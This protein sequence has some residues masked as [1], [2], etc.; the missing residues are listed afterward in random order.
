MRIFALQHRKKTFYFAVLRR[1][2]K[3]LEP[4]N[5]AALRDESLVP[6]I[7]IWAP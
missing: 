3:G 1:N 7:P 6:R 2:N 4:I 5:H